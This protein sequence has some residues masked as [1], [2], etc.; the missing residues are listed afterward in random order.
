MDIHLF[1][2]QYATHRPPNDRRIEMD[3]G[4]GKG[5]YLLSMAERFPHTHYIGADIM[6][7]RLRRIQKKIDRRKLANVQ[8]LRISAGQTAAHAMPDASL[9]RIHILCPDPWPKARH[10][11]NRLLTS[12]FLGRIA[13]K[14]KPDGILHLSSD[15]EPYVAFIKEALDGLTCYEPAPTGI[16]DVR[17]LKTDFE[18]NWERQGKVVEHIVLRRTDG[19]S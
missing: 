18:K 6:L 2:H 14:L 7:G 19:A 17:D 12:E 4:C 15:D 8:L 5:G 3:L 13:T 10:R 9:D 11:H 1:T 16:D